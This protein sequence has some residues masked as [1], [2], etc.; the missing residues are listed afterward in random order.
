MNRDPILFRVDG[1]PRLGWEQLARCLT[2]AAALQRRRRPT[3]FLSDLEPASL[4]LSIKRMPRT[5]FAFVSLTAFTILF[6][7][8][9]YPFH[10]PAFGL[11][12]VAITSMLLYFAHFV[13]T[14]LDNPFE[15]SWNVT[16]E[17]FGEL[18]TKIR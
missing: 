13:L 5:L 2:F 6:L 17:P 7:V 9:L 12:S 3:Y 14:D 1:T 10:R 11:V 15:G 4:A 16:S 8:L 18:V